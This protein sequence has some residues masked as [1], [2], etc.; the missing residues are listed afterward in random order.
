MIEFKEINFSY[1]NSLLLNNFSWLIPSNALTCILGWSGAGKSTLLRLIAG[2]EVPAKGELLL[3][4]QTIARDGKNLLPPYKRN[5]GFIFQD[6]ALWPHMTVYNNI[7]FPLKMN[8]KNNI[9]ERVEKWL[10]FFNLNEYASRY[11]NQLSGGQKQMVA[12]ARAMVS[13]PNILLMDE[14]LS[15][16]DISIKKKIL[17][18]INHIKDLLDITIVYVTHNY[19]EANRIADYVAVMEKGEIM[20]FGEKQKV[21]E[22]NNQ[23]IQMFTE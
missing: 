23:F 6:L 21:L 3:N 10:D 2:F 20:L 12:I 11:P 17:S 9:R 19:W 22:S 4:N 18:Y 1:G 16:L 7:A 5:I 13:E 14:P 8:K 15:N